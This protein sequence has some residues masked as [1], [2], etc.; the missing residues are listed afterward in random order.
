ML[1]YEGTRDLIAGT[2]VALRNYTYDAFDGEKRHDA[3][4]VRCE[5]PDFGV[6]AEVLQGKPLLVPNIGHCWMYV[7]SNSF[8][9]WRNWN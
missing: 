8:R 4:I 1:A 9:T 7:F 5:I 3:D 6:P 2:D